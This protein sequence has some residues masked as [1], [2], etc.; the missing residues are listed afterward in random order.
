MATNDQGRNSCETRGI[1]AKSIGEQK[2]VL[3]VVEGEPV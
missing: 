3:E 2:L 1:K